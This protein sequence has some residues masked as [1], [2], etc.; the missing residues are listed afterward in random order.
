MKATDLRIGNWVKW[1]SSGDE[2]SELNMKMDAG[3]LKAF[4]EKQIR[5]EPIKVDKT[6]LSK[7][8]TKVS[9]KEFEIELPVEWSKTHHTGYFFK[10][11]WYEYIATG[12]SH[13]GW[14][15][16]LQK[17]KAY[18][19]LAEMPP[20]GELFLWGYI[21]YLHQLQ[22]YYYSLTGSELEVVW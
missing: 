14:R 16:Y 9:D 22:N 18:P 4:D 13:T 7:C 19:Q 21:E 1:V 6:V 5:F 15:P 12:E 8:L 11:K 10:I 2:Y 17:P 3:N 20:L